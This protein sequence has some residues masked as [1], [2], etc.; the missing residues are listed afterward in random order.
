[1]KLQGFYFITDS[2]L[3]KNGIV[4]D[5]KDAIAGGARIIQYRE[6]YKD[7]WSMI[8][9]SKEL[10]KICEGKAIF[11]I[12]DRLDICLAVDADGVHLGQD[13]L[14]ETARSRL[15]EKIMGITVHNLEE[16]KAAEDKG[17]DY[18]GVSPIFHTDTKGDAGPAAGL[19]LVGEIKANCSLPIVAIGG[20]RL[21]NAKSV[22]G[23]GADTVC[24]M[25]ATIGDKT[26]ESV[27]AFS[28]LIG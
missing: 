18:L 24:A 11:I 3:S 4:Q 28:K 15:R 16:A 7:N 6:K 23:A 20:I 12:N 13:D 2:K 17:A 22:L 26:E 19:E 9:E 21:D 25:S 14:I 1:M 10:K 5:V 27:R 8:H